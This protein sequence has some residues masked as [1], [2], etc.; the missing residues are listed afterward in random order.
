[1]ALTYEEYTAPQ[2]TLVKPYY[3][4]HFTESCPKCPYHIKTGDEARVSYMEFYETFGFPYAQPQRG[5]HLVFYE[6]K[7]SSG[8]LVQKG[9]VSNCALYQLHPETMFF[10]MEGYLDALMY[11]YE[12]IAYITLYSNYTPCNERA[13]G[14]IDKMHDFLLNYPSTRLDIYFSALYHI[15][16]RH[17]ESGWN[18]EALHTLAALWPRVTINPISNGTWLAILHRFVN[19]VPWTALY[20]PVLPERASADLANAHQIATITG[21][22]PSYVDVAPHAKQ[23]RQ[24]FRPEGAKLYKFAQAALPAINGTPFASPY[25]PY[26]NRFN[27]PALPWSMYLPQPQKTRP[28]IVVRHLNM[29]GTSEWKTHSSP[30]LRDEQVTEMVVTNE[31]PLKEKASNS[32]GQEKNKARPKNTRRN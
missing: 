16:D 10:D 8:T 22:N 11:S 32:K 4:L 2:G 19:G 1:M 28:K 24:R 6:L 17:Y 18:T 12:D 30:T 26:A 21:V 14:C 25:Q 23:Q 20:N 5:N 13:H 27:L 7:L 9:Q 15:D 31:V 3:W 29:P